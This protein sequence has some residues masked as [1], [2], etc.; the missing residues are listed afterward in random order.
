MVKIQAV[1]L[2][3]KNCAA[4]VL[5]K[6]TEY[7]SQHQMWSTERLFPEGFFLLFSSFEKPWPLY[8]LDMSLRQIAMA[9]MYLYIRDI[10]L[11]SMP[12][13][14]WGGGG[15]FMEP[16]LEERQKML[17]F[18]SSPCRSGC[19]RCR[20]CPASTAEQKAAAP[21]LGLC[22]RPQ[23]HAVSVC[24]DRSLHTSISGMH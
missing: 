16:L 20:G 1:S 3:I 4:I 17:Y 21:G 6:K 11:Q 24:S 5:F 23:H 22:A 7:I 8:R 19:Y 15:G 2:F 12:G 14:G 18:A 9:P 10:Q 13:W